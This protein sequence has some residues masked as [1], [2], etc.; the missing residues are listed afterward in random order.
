[1]P[2]AKP[3]TAGIICLLFVSITMINSSYNKIPCIFVKCTIGK[4]RVIR[5]NTNTLEMLTKQGEYFLVKIFKLTKLK[6]AGKR[7]WS[8]GST[9]IIKLPFVNNVILRLCGTLYE[10][11]SVK[12]PSFWKLMTI[13]VVA[14]TRLK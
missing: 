11:F 7:L 14:K 8:A 1:M 6:H 4:T 10:Q 3:F 13:S 12:W 5:L 2:A 9:K